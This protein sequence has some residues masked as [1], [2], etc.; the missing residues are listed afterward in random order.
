M[1]EW[2][3]E[4][5]FALLVA[6]AIVVL[7]LLSPLKFGHDITDEY[8]VENLLYNNYHVSYSIEFNNVEEWYDLDPNE[9][10]YD[11]VYVD[12]LKND[13]GKDIPYSIEEHRF[14]FEWIS[15][16]QS[17]VIKINKSLAE[18]ECCNEH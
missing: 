8:E 4:T 11:I 9:D 2:L 16:P 1:S 3:K 6:V 18:G 7:T 5:A 17:Y 14:G 13:Y 15:Y 10:T 12:E